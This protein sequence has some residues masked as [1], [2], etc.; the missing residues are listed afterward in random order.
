MN[1]AADIPTVVPLNDGRVMVLQD[2]FSG[3]E[4]YDPAS[5]V[6]TITSPANGKFSQVTAVKLPDGIVLV[7][8]GASED[9]NTDD[10]L[11]IAEIYDPYA[12]TWTVTGPMNE[13]RI[14]HTLTLLPSG[15]VIAIGGVGATF[16]EPLA[17]SGIYDPV[18][19]TWRPGPEIAEG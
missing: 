3:A 1:T 5:D 11:P 14:H 12:D 6:W 16:T 13:M 19:N 17:T 10:T 7:T 4:I 15:Q 8:G 9:D 2:G 18:T